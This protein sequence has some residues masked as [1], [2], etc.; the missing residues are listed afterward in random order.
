MSNAKRRLIPFGISTLVGIVVAIT[1]LIGINASFL[2]IP[3]VPAAQLPGSGQTSAN[4]MM[5]VAETDYKG[6]T[7]RNLF[8]A[9]LQ[10]E[11]PKPKSSQEIEEETLTGIVKSMALKG[12]MLSAQKKGNYAVIDR[13]G[14]KGVWTYEVGDIIERGL[15]LKEVHRDSIKLEQGEFAAVLKLFS[16]VYERAP[17]NQPMNTGTAAQPLPRKGGQETAKLDLA[18]DIRKEGAV[19]LISKSLAEQLKSNNATIM[20]SIAVKAATDGLKVVAV[21]RGSIAQRIGIAPNDTLQEV[22]GHRLSS[23]EDMNKV[24]EDLK[25]ATSFDLKILRRG[26]AETLRYEIR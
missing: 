20:S 8:R 6:I 5:S 4:V 13:G 16:P 11:I 19:T 17:G 9:K 23:S 18:N 1:L 21:D 7:D 26:Q 14:Q 12:V 2:R 10:A 24:Y 22:N 3:E 15:V 25:N